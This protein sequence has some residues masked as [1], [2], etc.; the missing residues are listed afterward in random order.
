MGRWE[1][2]ETS[3]TRGISRVQ[4]D[5]KPVDSPKDSINVRFPHNVIAL[6]NF[7]KENWG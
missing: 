7:D 4:S 1:G 2:E 5:R 3:A 6:E